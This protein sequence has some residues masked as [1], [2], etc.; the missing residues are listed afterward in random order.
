MRSCLDDR[1]ALGIRDELPH[2]EAQRVLGD[3][4]QVLAVVPPV[5]VHVGR[6]VARAALAHAAAVPADGD[7]ERAVRLRHVRRR[8]GTEVARVSHAVAIGVFLKRVRDQPA[9]VTPVADAVAIGV[10]LCRVGDRRAIVQLVGDPVAVG[11][12]SPSGPAEGQERSEGT[13]HHHAAR[14]M[15]PSHD[16]LHE[17]SPFSPAPTVERRAGF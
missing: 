6:S 2:R 10:S 17:T 4:L 7:A 13:H 5:D 8:V 9:V 14:H 11:V 3:A 12:G 15:M 1:G 16:A